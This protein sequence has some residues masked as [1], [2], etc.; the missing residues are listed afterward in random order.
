MQIY[1]KN[2]QKFWSKRNVLYFKYIKGLSLTEVAYKIG[3][4]YD[5]IR[6]VHGIALIKYKEHTKSSWITHTISDNIIIDKIL[7]LF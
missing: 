3:Y 6:K 1:F 2:I 4:D 7:T 5:Y